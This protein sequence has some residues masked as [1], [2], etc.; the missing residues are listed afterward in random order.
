VKCLRQAG[1]LLLPCGWLADERKGRLAIY[2]TAR[3][4]GKPAR[5]AATL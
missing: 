3:I 5:C 2:S 1:C 4:W